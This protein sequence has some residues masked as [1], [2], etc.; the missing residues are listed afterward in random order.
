MKREWTNIEAKMKGFDIQLTA[1]NPDYEE[2]TEIIPN[3]DIKELY[4]MNSARFFSEFG[5]DESALFEL[6][7]SVHGI[8]MID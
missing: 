1:T 4:K 7:H 5:E 3:E 2:A 6:F 8:Q